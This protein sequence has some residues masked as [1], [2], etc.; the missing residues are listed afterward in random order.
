MIISFKSVAQVEVCPGAS[1][2]VKNPGSQNQ[3]LL[4]SKHDTSITAFK[5]DSDPV[6]QERL[7]SLFIDE[8]Q[9]LCQVHQTSKP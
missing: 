1:T 8:N 7:L 6:R 3:N 4:H 9:D 5:L 2:A